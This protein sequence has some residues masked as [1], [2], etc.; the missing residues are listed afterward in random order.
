V[1]PA[2]HETDDALAL[3]QRRAEHLAQ[4]GPTV[5]GMSLQALFAGTSVVWALGA[6]TFSFHGSGLVWFV[7]AAVGAVVSIA[8]WLRARRRSTLL[9]FTIEEPERPLPV[10]DK[11]QRGAVGR[12]I[13]GRQEVTPTT[14]PLVG[15]MLVSQQRSGRAVLLSV[16]G[17]GLGLVGLAGSLRDTALLVFILAVVVV[18]TIAAI[19]EGRTRKRVQA[20]VE[21]H[22]VEGHTDA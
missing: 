17:T 2:E 4:H 6:A 5:I 1:D 12:Q 7:L 8:S 13:R 11:A 15:A 22:A 10:L 19:L 20:Q 14:A 9:P 16:I 18:V 21:L 3:A